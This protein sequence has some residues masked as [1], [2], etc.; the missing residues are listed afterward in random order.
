[1]EYKRLVCEAEVT[2]DGVYYKGQVPTDST[3]EA[4]LTIQVCYAIVA[5]DIHGR[6]RFSMFNPPDL[7]NS[8]GET[9]LPIRLNNRVIRAGTKTPNI[10]VN[11]VESTNLTPE[12]KTL[13]NEQWAIFE[14]IA[15]NW[16]L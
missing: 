6:M 2:E 11:W 1:M 7:K 15:E 16:T 12:L 10:I 4:R 5:T 13:A 9:G 3:S 8:A 14:K